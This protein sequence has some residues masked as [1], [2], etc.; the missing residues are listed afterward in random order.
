[1]RV[2]M[3]DDHEIVRH[4]LRYIT[5]QEDDIEIDE[6][7][8]GSEA[9]EKILDGDYDVVVLDVTMP[10]VGGMEALKEIKGIRPK[11]PVLMLSVH[12]EERLAV[13]V[14]KA[15]AAGYLNKNMAAKELVVAI[16]KVSRGEM[17]VTPTLAVRLAEEVA[18]RSTTQPHERLSA[19]EFEVFRKL[20]AGNSVSNIGREMAL[21][22]KTISTYRTRI[23]QK[24]AMKDNAE[25]IRYALEHG[26][27]D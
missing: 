20:A 9:I 8:D 12:P 13:P 10:V 2:L 14:L 4:G 15:G 5:A 7:A 1:M 27:V 3:V 23:L 21:S 24:M 16:R 19:R 17:Y 11:L 25:I 6:A 26:L 18:G 22:V